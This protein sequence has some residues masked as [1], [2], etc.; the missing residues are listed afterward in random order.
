MVPKTEIKKRGRVAGQ[1]KS[2]TRIEDPVLGE[3]FIDVCKNSYDV[4]KKGS[5]QPLGYFSTFSG[6]LR[7]IAK[8]YIPEMGGKLTIK[9]YIAENQKILDKMKTLVE[10]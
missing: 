1:T 4:G 2:S 6:A 8:E 10:L 7:F 5:E 3:Y 9:E